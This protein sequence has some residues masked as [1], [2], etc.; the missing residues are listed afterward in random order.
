[1]MEADIKSAMLMSPVF[2][3]MFSG[4]CFVKSFANAFVGD[5][6]LATIVKQAWRNGFDPIAGTSKEES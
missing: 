2:R 3:V 4:C 6:K 1:M 5:L